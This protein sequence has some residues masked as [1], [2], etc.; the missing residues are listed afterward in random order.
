[1]GIQFSFNKNKSAIS[2][3]IISII[4]IALII[5]LATLGRHVL[6]LKDDVLL[7]ITITSIE[8]IALI[9]SLAI[10]IRQLY[11]SKEIARATFIVD[12]NKSYVENQD[13]I[14][15]YNHLQACFDNKY[16]ESHDCSDESKCHLEFEKGVISNYLTF[17]ETIYLL[18]KN[19]VIS[20]EIIDDLFAYRFFLI[21]H[22]KLVQQ[23]KLGHQPEN[24]TNIFCLEK[25]WLE[26]RKKH[27]P[28]P[29]SGEK[30]IYEYLPLKDLVTEAQYTE[31]T[32]NCKQKK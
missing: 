10:A 23:E 28:S 31:L 25:E 7:S 32:K 16:K 22:S 13:F 14:N 15:L 12:L 29:N 18:Y 26:Y 4:V 24:F 5:A 3:I 11:D 6:S 8:T 2:L 20:F 19:G 9:V 21:A 30:S 17:F 1:M 27:K